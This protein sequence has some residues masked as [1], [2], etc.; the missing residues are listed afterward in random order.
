MPVEALREHFKMKEDNAA[1][2]KL[3][4]LESQH[5]QIWRKRQSTSGFQ[6]S[7]T[8][9]RSLLMTRIRRSTS[10]MGRTI[11]P[12]TS[13]SLQLWLIIVIVIEFMVDIPGRKCAMNPKNKDEKILP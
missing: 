13:A 9:N 12:R 5:L 7:Q 1:K 6:I 8:R 2:S 11:C 10:I 3:K 4:N